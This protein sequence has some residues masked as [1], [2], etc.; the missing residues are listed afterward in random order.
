MERQTCKVSRTNTATATLE[1]YH[2]GESLTVTIMSGDFHLKSQSFA[3]SGKFQRASTTVYPPV[4]MS[5]KEL[6]VLMMRG[7]RTR[8]RRKNQGCGA[9]VKMKWLRLRSSLFS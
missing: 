8:Q 4:K 1:E 7:K 9:V 5:D 2:P 6:Q 3:D